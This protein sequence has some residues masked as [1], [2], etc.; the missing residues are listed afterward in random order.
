MSNNDSF[1]G[2]IKCN[3]TISNEIKQ[4]DVKHNPWYHNRIIKDYKQIQQMNKSLLDDTGFSYGINAYPTDENMYGMWTATIEGQCI[5]GSPYEA[6]MFVAE[7]H[8]PD[9]YPFK[10]PTIKFVTPIYHCNVAKDGMMWLNVGDWT[11]TMSLWDFLDSVCDLLKKPDEGNYVS[12]LVGDLHEKNR[13]EYN[14]KATEHTLL[15]AL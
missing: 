7:M 15:Y 3:D 8:I 10:P 11:P 5:K 9:E 12:S 4:N 13:A 6:G 14:R 1:D 2:E